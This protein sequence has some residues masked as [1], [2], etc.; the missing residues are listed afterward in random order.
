VTKT[1][2]VPEKRIVKG[3]AI[4]IYLGK[5]RVKKCAKSNDRQA[6]WPQGTSYMSRGSIAFRALE[7]SESTLGRFDPQPSRFE[8]NFNKGQLKNVAL[9]RP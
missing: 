4:N 9:R 8:M 5:V 6:G 2:C 3:W 7:G 1:Q